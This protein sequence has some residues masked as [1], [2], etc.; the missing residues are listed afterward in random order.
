VFLT[1]VPESKARHDQIKQDQ[2]HDEQNHEAEVKG[3]HTEPK[4]RDEATEQ[5]QWRICNREDTLGYHQQYARRTPIAGENLY[6]AEDHPADQDHQVD[7][8]EI[9]EDFLQVLHK[10]TLSLAPALPAWLLISVMSP[11]LAGWHCLLASSG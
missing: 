10:S 4:G 2:N 6:P 1:T 11:L 8:Q 3:Y 7:H 5:P 9:M